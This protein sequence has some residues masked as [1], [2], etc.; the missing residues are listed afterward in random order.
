M[1]FEEEGGLSPEVKSI[2]ASEKVI[3][4]VWIVVVACPLR[5]CVI[6][7]EVVRKDLLLG[8]LLLL[9][10]LP[11][12]P[13]LVF[14]GLGFR[15]KAWTVVVVLR[16]FKL[17]VISFDFAW[18]DPL[19]LLVLFDSLPTSSIVE[20]VVVAVELDGWI[21]L[22]LEKGETKSFSAIVLGWAS[23]SARGISPTSPPPPPFVDVFVS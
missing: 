23:S 3:G 19:I 4:L 1:I 9:V 11:D 13:D 16:P 18:E 6:L 5:V 17:L 21:F 2:K 8:L 10:V 20:V 22:F 14:E 15:I 7:L 12:L